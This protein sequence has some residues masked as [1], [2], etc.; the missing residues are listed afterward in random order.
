MAGPHDLGNLARNLVEVGATLRETVIERRAAHE[1]RDVVACG[2]AS[3]LHA[4]FI[5]MHVGE[6]AGC[7]I[8]PVLWKWSAW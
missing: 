6:S 7:G 2:W 3:S 8:G 1:A 4:H 5:Q